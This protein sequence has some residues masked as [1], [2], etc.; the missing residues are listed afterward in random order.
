MTTI[1]PAPPDAR[2]FGY[3]S[4][5]NGA[6]H[7]YPGLAPA[8]LSG[9]RR[10]WRRVPGRRV[11][12]LSVRRVPGGGIDGATA[13]VPGGDWASLDLREAAYERIDCADA[14]RP[15][16]GGPVALYAVPGA[17]RGAG[18][19]DPPVLL[20]YLDTVAAGFA[21]LH[22]PDGPAGFFEETDGWAM[23]VADD[24][25]APIYPRH[26]AVGAVIEALVDEE[27]RRRGV[28][29]VPAGPGWP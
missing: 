10:H 29:V 24:R 14:L 26:L 11:C 7:G 1:D 13:R 22:G 8:R 23:P 28:R 21:A 2:F 4:L 15:A 9:W 5:V 17:P 16:P 20:S 12:V 3:G 6:T 19:D 18:P 25:A 27:L